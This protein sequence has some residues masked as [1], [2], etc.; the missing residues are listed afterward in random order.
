MYPL[1]GPCPSREAPIGLISQGLKGLD[2]V[3]YVTYGGAEDLFCAFSAP[4]L[5]FLYDPFENVLM[6]ESA[7]E[8]KIDDVWEVYLNSKHFFWPQTQ[9]VYGAEREE[10]KNMYKS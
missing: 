9:G 6:K 7:K 1:L 2:F 8:V 5:H 4:H 3:E 10:E